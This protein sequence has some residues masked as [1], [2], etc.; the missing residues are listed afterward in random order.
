MSFFTAVF[1]SISNLMTKKGRTFITALAGSIGIIGIAAILALASG[2]NLYI[3]DIEADTMSAYPLTVDSS[4]IDITSFLGGEGNEG[5]PR[6]SQNRDKKEKTDKDQVNVVNTVTALFSQQNKNDLKSFKKH[7]DK[8]RSDLDPY[9]KNIQYKYGITPE[10][11]LKD[12]KAELRQVNPDTIFAESGF[13]FGGGFDFISG[14]GNFGMKNFDELPGDN[15]I[16]QEQYDLAAGRWPKEKNELIVVLLESGS[17]TDTTMY[18]LGLKDRNNLKKT[19]EDFSNEA[20][21]VCA[22]LSLPLFIKLRAF[23]TFACSKTEA[24]FLELFKTKSE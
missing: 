15:D 14:A 11:Y 6:P 3:A 16:F 12:E 21:A 1:L 13:D 2:I 23:I 5:L 8:N 7:I 24:E 4:G 10:I 9:L 19:F 22:S 20:K 18:T 17:I